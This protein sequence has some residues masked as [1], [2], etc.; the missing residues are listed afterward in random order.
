MLIMD[1]DQQDN[2]SVISV[3]MTARLL[4]DLFAAILSTSSG[5]LKLQTLLML[6]PKEF[7]SVR[8][9]SPQSPCAKQAVV[10]SLLR[11]R[12][13]SDAVILESFLLLVGT[14]SDVLLLLL[15][16]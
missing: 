9:I 10:P 1:R 8:R 6:S 4:M 15:L 16:D 14:K 13:V 11:F 12:C 5:I 7:I 2:L 3:I